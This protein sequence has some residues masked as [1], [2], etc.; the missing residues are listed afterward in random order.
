MLSTAD[1]LIHS[2][3]KTLSEAGE[4]IDSNIR[5]EVESA[6]SDLKQAVKNKQI[7]GILKKT[8][9]LNQ[10]A[11]KMAQGFYQ[12][13]GANAHKNTSTAPPNDDGVMDAEYLVFINFI[14]DNSKINTYSINS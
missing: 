3:Q 1:A 10:A 14:F 7:N 12:Q 11:H 6:V 8:Q 9:N 4:K 13:P 5:M 2:T